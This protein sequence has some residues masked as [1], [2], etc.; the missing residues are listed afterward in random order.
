MCNEEILAYIFVLVLMFGLYVVIGMGIV[1]LLWED[2][3]Y[4]VAYMFFWPVMLVA[5]AFKQLYEFVRE[6][7]LR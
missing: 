2:D 6:E 5:K 3:E 1:L 4:L 7:I